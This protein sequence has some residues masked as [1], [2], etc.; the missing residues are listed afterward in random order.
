[1]FLHLF[2]DLFNL[3][4]RKSSNL[5]V[6]LTEPEQKFFLDFWFIFLNNF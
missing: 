1:M 2:K 3:K 5:T 6:L 4:Y